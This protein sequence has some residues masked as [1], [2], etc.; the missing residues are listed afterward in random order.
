MSGLVPI[1]VGGIDG[2]SLTG[3]SKIEDSYCVVSWEKQ[4]SGLV[5]CGVELVE[6]PG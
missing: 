2:L 5:E 1:Q 6:L 4:K 3:L